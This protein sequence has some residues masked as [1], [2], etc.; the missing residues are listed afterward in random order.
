MRQRHFAGEKLFVDYAGRT[1]PIYGRGGEEAFRAQLF[2]SAMG[3]SG[4]AYAEAT[5]S[6]TLPDWLA[7]TCGRWSFTARAPTILVPDNP[8]VGVTTSGSLRA[9]SAAIVRGDGRPLPLRRDPGAAVSPEGQKPG[10]ADAYY[11]CV[12]GSWRGCAISGSSAWMNST[13]RS[14]RCW[15][16]STTGRT[17]VCRDRAAASSRRSIGRRCARCRPSPYV[18]RRVEGASPSRSTTTSISIGITTA[19]RTRWSA[20]ARG[21]ASRAAR[22]E[23]FFRSE[24]VAS[25]VRSYQRGV[26]TTVRRAHAE[27]ASGA[28]RVVAQAPDPVG[29]IDRSEHRRGASSI[30]CAPSPSR[31]RLSSLPGALEPEPRVRREPPGGRERTGRA[32]AAVPPARACKSILESGRDLTP[33]TEPLDLEFAD[34]R[35]RARARLLPLTIDKPSRRRRMLTNPTIETLKSLKLHGMIASARGTAANPDHPGAVVRG[36]HRAHRRSRAALS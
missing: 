10:G 4:Y 14:G 31:A 15:W 22:V 30:C 35:Q 33:A 19:S 20:T 21:R 3:A 5:R 7:V 23:V 32:A 1:V 16:S 13:R 2:V 27:V 34:A 25:H 26:H 28:R 18:Y 9:G 11:W 8:K 36:A 6:E 17:N 12:A 24:R 29:R